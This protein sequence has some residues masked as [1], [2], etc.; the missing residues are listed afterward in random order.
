MNR[1]VSE[2][3]PS[4]D[5][6]GMKAPFNVLLPFCLRKRKMDGRITQVSLKLS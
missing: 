2:A 5:R 1:L 6:K 4:I 3:I